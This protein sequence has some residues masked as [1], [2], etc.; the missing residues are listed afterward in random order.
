MAQKR[1]KF[2]KSDVEICFEKVNNEGLCI[3][4]L[5]EFLCYKLLG[6]LVVLRS[7]V[8][9]MLGRLYIPKSKMDWDMTKSNTTPSEFRG[10]IDRTKMEYP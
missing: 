8:C 9:L 4:A 1:F 6:G 7:H 10:D 3:A 2:P 5:A